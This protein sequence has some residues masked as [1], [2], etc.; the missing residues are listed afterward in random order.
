MRYADALWLCLL[1]VMHM[2]RAFQPDCLFSQYQ[3][4]SIKKNTVFYM[5]I[6]SAGASSDAVYWLKT[7]FL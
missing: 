5:A 3:T 2:Q 7:A 6:L 4:N 1:A